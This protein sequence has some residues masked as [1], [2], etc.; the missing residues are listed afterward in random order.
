MRSFACFKLYVHVHFEQQVASGTAQIFS[1][2]LCVRGIYQQMV[3][4]LHTWGF[5][6]SL[7]QHFLGK[8][9]KRGFLGPGAHRIARRL[10][11]GDLLPAII[12]EQCKGKA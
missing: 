7:K 3:E 9:E 12:E 8:A 10:V 11:W 1:S 4:V 2:P 5:A 6:G